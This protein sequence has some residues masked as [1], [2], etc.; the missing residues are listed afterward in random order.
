MIRVA[1]LYWASI[2]AK[3]GLIVSFFE[4][5]LIMSVYPDVHQRLVGFDLGRK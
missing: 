4:G 5:V 3:E 2:M 1:C